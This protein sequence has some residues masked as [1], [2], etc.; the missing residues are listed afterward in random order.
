MTTIRTPIVIV[1]LLLLGM[2]L[3][4]LCL[5]SESEVVYGLSLLAG[6]IAFA[7]GLI[8]ATIGFVRSLSILFRPNA[9]RETGVRIP[10]ATMFAA[11]LV[12]CV[13]IVI[14]LFLHASLKA[15]M[16]RLD[17]HRRRHIEE[18]QHSGGGTGVSLPDR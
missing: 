10:M 3:F 11:G 14:V 7:A 18:S 8:L 6:M 1:S 5:G 4:V 9:R 17:Q 15:E 12:W 13:T 16:Q 2:S